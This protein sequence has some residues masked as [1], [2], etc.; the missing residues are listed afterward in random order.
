MR[1]HICP[2]S[3]VEEEQDIRVAIRVRTDQLI[4]WFDANG[5]TTDI[6]SSESNSLH[7]RLSRARQL[8]TSRSMG[9]V[10]PPDGRVAGQ[11]RVCYTRQPAAS[12]PRRVGIVSA[13]A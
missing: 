5:I 8:S 9:I 7:A 6:A 2:R 13:C 11:G 3:R 4:A 12:E 1:S 10:R